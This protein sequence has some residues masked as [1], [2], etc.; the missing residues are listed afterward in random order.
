M[1]IKA[2]NLDLAGRNKNIPE[3]VVHTM[4]LECCLEVAHADVVF[5]KKFS[6]YFYL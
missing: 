4:T 6:V 3:K 1:R 5:K 2:Y